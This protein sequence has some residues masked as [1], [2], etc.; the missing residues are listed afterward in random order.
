M[1]FDGPRPQDGWQ[2]I[3]TGYGAQGWG[4]HRF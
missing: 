2:T 3:G 1:R 4:T